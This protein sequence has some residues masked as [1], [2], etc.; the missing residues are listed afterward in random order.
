MMYLED[1]HLQLDHCSSM[2]LK[3]HR[4]VALL[5]QPSA[6]PLKECKDKGCYSCPLGGAAAAWESQLGTPGEPS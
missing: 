6:C 5:H 2:F 3:P 4:L 1:Q